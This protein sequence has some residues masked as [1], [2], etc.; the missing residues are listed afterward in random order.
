[1]HVLDMS[2]NEEVL[3][4]SFPLQCNFTHMGGGKNHGKRLAVGKSIISMAKTLKTAHGQGS[5][6]QGLV[7]AGGPL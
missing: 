3:R 2:H 7:P 6:A 1:M 4:F 5:C